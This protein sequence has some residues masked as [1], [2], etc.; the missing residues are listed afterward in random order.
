MELGHHGAGHGGLA[1]SV[2]GDFEGRGGGISPFNLQT[3]TAFL[4]CF[5][6]V[7]WVLYDTLGVAPAVALLVG[8]VAGV[9]GGAV[10]FWFLVKVLIAGQTFM[11]PDN[12]RMEGTL[13]RVTRAISETG[14]GEIVYSRDGSRHSEGARSA[15]GLPIPV[16][17]EVV[18]VRYEEGLAH[19]EPWASFSE[20]G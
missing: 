18:I 15:T 7:G 5:G 11:D 16:G 12:S 19:V 4:A 13:G 3:I 1:H 10:V 8:A 6:G 2:D 20:E 14:I 17:T 9:A